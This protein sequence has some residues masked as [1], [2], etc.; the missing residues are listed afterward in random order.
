M[1]R[2]RVGIVHRAA[3]WPVTRRA[4]TRTARRRANAAAHAARALLHELRESRA[5]QHESH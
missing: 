4:V 1:A 5:Q 2:L 3:T